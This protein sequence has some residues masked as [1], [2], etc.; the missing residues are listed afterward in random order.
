MRHVWRKSRSESIRCRKLGFISCRGFQGHGRATAVHREQ[1]CAA[2]LLTQL[3]RWDSQGEILT[4]GA[5]GLCR[6]SFSL[7]RETFWFWGEKIKKLEQL[8]GMFEPNLVFVSCSSELRPKHISALWSWRTGKNPPYCSCC[9]LPTSCLRSSCKMFT[10]VSVSGWLA[11]QVGSKE[12]QILLCC[13]YLLHLSRPK[14]FLGVCTLLQFYFG[15]AFYFYP[16][17]LYANIGTSCCLH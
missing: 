14:H 16:I 13:T 10:V 17:H 15:M 6:L 7:P 9:G 12:V 2:T 8:D 1:P 4:V 11:A 3:L 5:G